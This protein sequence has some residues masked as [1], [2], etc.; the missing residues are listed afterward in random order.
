MDNATIIPTRVETNLLL[1]P[2]LL[3]GKETPEVTP[4]TETFVV[5]TV[6]ESFVRVIFV[7]AGDLGVDVLVVIVLVVLAKNYI[8][9]WTKKLL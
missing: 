7:F 4:V 8:R 5:D 9:L 2:L 6:F 3:G 1:L